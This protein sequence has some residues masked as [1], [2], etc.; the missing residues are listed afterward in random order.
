MALTW[1]LTQ[2]QSRDHW[3][4]SHLKTC[5][6]TCLVSGQGWL[7]ELGAGQASLSFLT[8]RN[9]VGFLT[10]W[11]SPRTGSYTVPAFPQSKRSKKE[12][13]MKVQRFLMTK[14]QKSSSF[15]LK[16][17]YWPKQSHISQDSREW[18]K[19]LHLSVSKEGIDGGHLENKWPS[20]WIQFIKNTQKRDIFGLLH[21]ENM[22]TFR[23]NGHLLVK[24]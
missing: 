16:I 1:D 3:G 15:T 4:W 21:K 8:P 23:E 10:T 24:R 2:P 13:Q 19:R 20:F 12:K 11:Q 18:K 14:S 9:C 6:F 22:L 7:E 5:L 17:S